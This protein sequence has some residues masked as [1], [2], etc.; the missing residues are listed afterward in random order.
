MSDPSASIQPLSDWLQVSR[1]L[2]IALEG[3]TDD[4]LNFRGGPLGW[5]IRETVHHLV[6]S[7]L[8]A[9]TIVIAAVGAGG[10][11]F[12]CSWLNPYQAWMERMGYRG[13]VTPAI[14][15]STA[16]CRYV[17]ALLSAAPDGLRRDIELLGAPGTE[18]YRVTVEQ[19]IVLEVEHG[20]QHL[21]ELD[22]MLKQRPR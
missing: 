21:H 2:E 13:T 15:A 3:M 14:E 6:E 5:S 8:V 9:C 12:D 16:S 11:K 22:E 17:S 18:P 20:R 10:C 1:T 4:D 19:M 7:N